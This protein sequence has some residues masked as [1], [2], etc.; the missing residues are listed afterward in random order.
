MRKNADCLNDLMKVNV[1]K[2]TK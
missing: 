1:L 2:L